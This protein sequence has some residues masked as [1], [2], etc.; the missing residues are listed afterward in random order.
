MVVIQEN[1]TNQFISKIQPDFI[2]K[3][4]I[5]TQNYNHNCTEIVSYDLN[6]IKNKYPKNEQEIN[7]NV[8]TRTVCDRS[9]INHCVPLE[10]VSSP[11]LSP[12]PTTKAFP[13]IH[14]AC[15]QPCKRLF[16]INDILVEKVRNVQVQELN[17]VISLSLSLLLAAML[18]T[19][20]CFTVYMSDHMKN[21]NFF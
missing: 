6:G 12:L 10:Q 1:N 7:E 11:P 14:N 15:R 19:I 3:I 4:Y 5:K 17:K 20:H 16:E 21:S 18:Q 2:P 9:N 13:S 8:E